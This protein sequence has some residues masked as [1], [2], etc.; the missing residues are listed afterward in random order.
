MVLAA[1]AAAVRNTK[2]C[3]DACHS[4]LK[5]CHGC[6]FHVLSARV[7][8]HL[9]GGSSVVKG[10]L[11]AVLPGDLGCAGHCLLLLFM[12]RRDLPL[13]KWRL[14]GKEEQSA[15][16]PPVCR[17]RE[18]SFLGLFALQGSS[19]MLSFPGHPLKS[20]CTR[21]LEKTSG[22]PLFSLLN[23]L[24]CFLPTRFPG[25]ALTTLFCMNCIPQSHKSPCSS[26]PFDSGLCVQ[27]IASICLRSLPSGVPA[28]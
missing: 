2:K 27:S 9:G 13:E 5:K 12:G 19:L 15:L 26:S 18:A 21:A 17:G 11:Q 22:L 28:A 1:G 6:G 4:P 20:P 10:R 16:P 8:E 14:N 24:F 23:C 25:P 7:L 3:L